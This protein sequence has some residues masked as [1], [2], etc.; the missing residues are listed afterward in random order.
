MNK[1]KEEKQGNSYT[2]NNIEKVDNF[3][4]N[5]KVVNENTTVNITVNLTLNFNGERMANLFRKIC[6][7]LHIPVKK[8]L[9][10]HFDGEG[11]FGHRICMIE[12]QPS[13]LVEVLHELSLSKEAEDEV[14]IRYS[15]M[16]LHFEQDN[17]TLSQA[18]KLA[19]Y[20]NQLPNG[21][22]QHL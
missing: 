19:Q 2:I 22:A 7:K 3:N 17:L 15:S 10:A 11:D 21:S 14:S 16:T 12:T 18:I 9:Q 1:M 4:P 6:S 13:V 5:A 20:E 8:L